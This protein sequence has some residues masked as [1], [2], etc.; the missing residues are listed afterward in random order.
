MANSAIIDLIVETVRD[1]LIYM[2]PIIGLLAGLTFVFSFL[3]AV[4][5]GWGRKTFKD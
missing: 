4:T 1:M 3:I 2:L 5:I